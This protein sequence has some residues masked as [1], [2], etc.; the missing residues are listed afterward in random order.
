MPQSQRTSPSA[1][2][3]GSSPTSATSQRTISRLPLRHARARDVALP[4]SYSIWNTRRTLHSQSAARR[5]HYNTRRTIATAPH[6]LPPV[7]GPHPPLTRATGQDSSR[8]DRMPAAAPYTYPAQRHRCSSVTESTHGSAEYPQPTLTQA[9]A[10]SLCGR[11]LA[12]PT[13]T[14]HAARSTL[15]PSHDRQHRTPPAQPTF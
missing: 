3:D 11:G 13:H 14:R 4:M 10:H 5:H 1:S 6:A 12:P 9:H 8:R 2:S 15:P 7:V